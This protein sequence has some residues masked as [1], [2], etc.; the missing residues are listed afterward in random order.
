MK[1]IKSLFNNY[2]NLKTKT[3][4]KY[5]KNIKIFT[6]NNSNLIKYYI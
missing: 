2:L 3:N 6:L 4:S 5:E 1:F